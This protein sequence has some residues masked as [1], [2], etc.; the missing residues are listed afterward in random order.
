MKEKKEN[1]RDERKMK[2]EAFVKVGEGLVEHETGK[3][4][5]T[6][7]VREVGTH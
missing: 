1:E 3:I 7:K 6:E 5:D 4:R 2:E